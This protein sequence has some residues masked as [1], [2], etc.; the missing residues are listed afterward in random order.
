[1]YG[2]DDY[3]LVRSLEE[4]I[5]EIGDQAALEMN[6]T[7]LEG[8]QLTADELRNVCGTVPF[9]A[10][11][12]LI[13]VRGLL[14]RFEPRNRPRRQQRN[15]SEADQPDRHKPFSACLGILPD[16]T[17]LVLTDDR[18]T[19]RNP[20]F[21]ELAG[22]ATVKTFPLLKE[23]KLREWVQKQVTVEGSKISPRA[24]NLLVRLVGSNLWILAS[25]VEKLV[26]Y[27]SGRIIEEEDINKVVGYAQQAT[28]FNMVDAILE[29]KTEQ[30]EQALQQLLQR[31]A[32]PT[33]LL[34]MLLRQVRMIV[35]AKEL[36]IQKHTNS[37]IQAKLGLTAEFALR[38]ILEQAT[39]YNLPRLRQV[40]HYLLETDLSIKT[41]KS[42]AELAL[43]VLVVELSRRDGARLIQTGPGM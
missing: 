14:G 30:A 41:G 25:E 36:K 1:L 17:I 2:Q 20:L 15:R 9:M 43:T 19:N 35:R 11:K 33:Y 3:S 34:S 24:A 18:I 16:S 21:K 13:I 39:R 28:V 8:Q 32:T 23:P 5:K 27:T 29:S 40:Y 7:N 38:K 12:R 22:K 4:I 26:S 31:G 37:D 6:T 10:E 42:E